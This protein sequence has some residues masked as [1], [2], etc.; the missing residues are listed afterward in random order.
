MF[1]DLRTTCPECEGRRYRKEILDVKWKGQSIADVL[2]LTAREAFRAF[3]SSSAIVKKLKVV[4]DVGLEYLRLGQPLESL[5][6]GECQ[7]LKLA[8]HLASS[9]KTGC[10]FLMDEPTAGLH[11]TDIVKLLECF[12]R[13]LAAGH[14]LIVSEHDPDLHAAADQVIAR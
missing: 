8:G 14:S 13:L 2:D 6:G 3:G 9:R 12:E 1:A 4:L 5:A 7:L 10:L 11:P